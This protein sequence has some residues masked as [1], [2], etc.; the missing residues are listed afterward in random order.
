MVDIREGGNRQGSLFGRW[1]Q[2]RGW[3]ETCHDSSTFFQALFNASSCPHSRPKRIKSFLFPSLRCLLHIK[4]LRDRTK[5]TRSRWSSFS[6][7]SPD[8]PPVSF[9]DF[10]VC[11]GYKQNI[12]RVVRL[13]RFGGSTIKRF[14]RAMR[15][16]HHVNT[17]KCLPLLLWIKYNAAALASSTS[18]GLVDVILPRRRHLASSAKMVRQYSKRQSRRF[19]VQLNRHN[20]PPP[21]KKFKRNEI[22][23]FIWVAIERL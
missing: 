19:S 18:S 13:F 9:Q 15:S 2:S 16:G 12:Q 14:S 8:E 20:P 5:K 11:N 7:V 1:R 17:A 23:F 21:K 4:W 22:Y 10:L 6:V 3:T